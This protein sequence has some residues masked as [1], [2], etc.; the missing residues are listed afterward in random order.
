MLIL[1]A[2]RLK[3]LGLLDR[4]LLGT[5]GCYP[6]QALAIEAPAFQHLARGRCCATDVDLGTGLV[7]AYAGLSEVLVRLGLLGVLLT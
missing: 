3:T 4:Q 7:T 1:R 2:K 6:C 5:R